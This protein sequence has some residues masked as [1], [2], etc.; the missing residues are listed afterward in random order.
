MAVAQALLPVD[1]QP[2]QL[3]GAQCRDLGARAE[4][5]QRIGHPDPVAAEHAAAAGR[6]CALAEADRVVDVLH[7]VAVV[8]HRDAASPELDPHPLRVGVERVIDELADHVVRLVVRHALGEDHVRDGRRFA[9]VFGFAIDRQ[10]R[11]GQNGPMPQLALFEGSHVPRTAAREALGR[12]ALGEAC[13]HLAQMSGATEEGADAA[14]LERISSALRAASADPLAALHAG[15]ASA[16]AIV[17]PR[18]FL[19][20]EEWF[21]LYA[22]R[23]AHELAADPARRFRGWLGLHFAFAAGEP[24]AVRDSARRIVEVVPPGPAWVEASRLAF[25]AGDSTRA[26]E[27]LHA[28]CLDSAIELAPERPVL[29]RSSVFAL[30]AAP[31]LPPLPATVED[32]FAGVRDFDGLPG[33]R[34]RWVAVVGEIDR[35][36]APA[37]PGGAEPLQDPA[38]SKDP[39]RA[40]LAALRA[41]R[42]SRERD[43]ARSPD[44]C[45]DRELRARRR[46]QR[47]A[48]A[49]LERYLRG[50]GGALL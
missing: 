34:T 49:L 2:V 38:P 41:A 25:A 37:D 39:A 20:A 22:Q 23:I 12:G 29:E 1:A 15:F 48:P 50:L 21:R 8:G 42:R 32:L 7:S 47:I 28:A 36:L 46:M 30:D 16:L 19:A 6:A 10:D 35:V 26:R 43:G 27:W 44:R 3:A 18:G 13:A 4:L 9:A 5:A 33:P 40:F 14:R 11:G 24:E 17:E 31:A 45:S